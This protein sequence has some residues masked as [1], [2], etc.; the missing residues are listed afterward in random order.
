MAV[1]R[2]EK[3]KSLPVAV[4]VRGGFLHFQNEGLNPT[5]ILEVA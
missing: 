2:R 1:Q 4:K 5:K 3:L